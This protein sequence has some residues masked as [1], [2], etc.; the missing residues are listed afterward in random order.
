MPLGDKLHLLCGSHQHICLS[1]SI[2]YK[3]HRL[4]SVPYQEKPNSPTLKVN[5]VRL[6][7]SLKPAAALIHWRIHCFNH[8]S[9]QTTVLYNY[10]LHLHVITLSRFINGDK[11]KNQAWQVFHQS[12]RAKTNRSLLCPWEQV[13]PLPPPLGAALSQPHRGGTWILFRQ[14]EWMNYLTWI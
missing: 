5:L 11:D 12:E 8:L 3:P 7:S 10:S 4:A 6:P 2:K 9:N 1:W 13:P 14:H